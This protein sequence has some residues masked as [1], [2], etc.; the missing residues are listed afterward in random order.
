MTKRA[1][2]MDRTRRQITEAAVRLHTSVGPSATSMSAVADEAGVTRVTLYRHFPSSEALF[3]ACMAHWRALHPSP[4]PAEWRAVSSFEQRVRRAVAEVYAWYGENG[5]DLFPLY[6][7][8]AFTPASTIAA[9]RAN[10]D[11]MVESI[12]AGLELPLAHRRRLVAICGHLLRFWTW[13]S[14]RVE[15]G[16]SANEAS[17]V[18]AEILLRAVR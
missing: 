10:T 6:R 7:D 11:R 13:H 8:A 4:D 2:L 14:L 5:D 9:R 18:A 3:G 1:E 16:M 15:Q 12:L 17:E